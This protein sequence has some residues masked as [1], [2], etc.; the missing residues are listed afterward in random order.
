MS[1]S[2]TA[3]FRCDSS[4]TCPRQT[5]DTVFQRECIQFLATNDP[6]LERVLT[7]GLSPMGL[8][9]QSVYW[10][11]QVL[12]WAVPGGAGSTVSADSGIAI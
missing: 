7:L 8:G 6:D 3:T 9:R 4:S 1:P 11:A 2:R 5:G 10:Y 12:C